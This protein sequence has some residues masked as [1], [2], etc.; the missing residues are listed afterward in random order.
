MNK[1]GV[2]DNDLACVYTGGLRLTE[3]V[4]KLFQ[5]SNWLKKPDLSYSCGQMTLT[6]VV[7]F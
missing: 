2:F 6:K 1:N 3:E 5:T 4:D 7:L